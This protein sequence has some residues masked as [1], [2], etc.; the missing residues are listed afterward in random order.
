[1]KFIPLI[2]SPRP[3]QTAQGQAPYLFVLLGHPFVP[4]VEHVQPLGL[5]LPQHLQGNFLQ[6]VDAGQGIRC[7]KTDKGPGSGQPCSPLQS[8]S[9]PP[10]GLQT[11]DALLQMSTN[12][13]GQIQQVQVPTLPMCQGIRDTLPLQVSVH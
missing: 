12:V 10:S 8:A 9:R 11:H 3:P 2:S 1:M 4:V 5:P 13:A 6:P 7:V